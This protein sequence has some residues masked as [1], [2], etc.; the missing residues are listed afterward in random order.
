MNAAHPTRQARVSGGVR[1]RVTPSALP[2]VEHD[3]PHCFRCVL[4][5]VVCP[6]ATGAAT[7]YDLNAVAAVLT[8]VDH[9]T[10]VRAIDSTHRLDGGERAVALLVVALVV[11]H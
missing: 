2:V 1:G 5:A 11:A 10:P 6:P 7:D 9:S 3:L 4:D 8:L